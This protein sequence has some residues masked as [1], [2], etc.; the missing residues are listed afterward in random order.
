MGGARR[1]PWIVA[2][3]VAGVL[4]AGASTTAERVGGCAYSGLAHGRSGI[5][6]AAVHTARERPLAGHGLE[7]FAAA[8]RS[9]QLR[10]RAVPVQYAH[11]LPLEAWV[12]LGLAGVVLVLG[13]YGAVM[14]SALRATRAAAALLGPAALAFLAANLLDW[15]WHLAGSGA[16]WAI[17]VGGL[18]GSRDGALVSRRSRT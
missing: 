13:L 12:E 10:E 2:V 1:A 4:T 15:P 16:L 14:L 17:A 18:L 5:W 3:C 9:R 8:S 11:N 7:S 6:R